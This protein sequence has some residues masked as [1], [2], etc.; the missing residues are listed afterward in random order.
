[1]M[2]YEKKEHVKRQ[3]YVDTLYI[4]DVIL[5]KGRDVFEISHKCEGKRISNISYF[6]TPSFQCSVTW[7][8]LVLTHNS[9]RNSSWFFK[10]EL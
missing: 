3:V 8:T 10:N 4:F 9:F 6:F 7:S 1:M 5:L 2:S